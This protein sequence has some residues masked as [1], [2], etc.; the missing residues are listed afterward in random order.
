[1]K[2]KENRKPP[3]KFTG[4]LE[5]CDGL[6]SPTN[7]GIFYYKNGEHH[8]IDAPA[9]V[10]DVGAKIWYKNGNVHN[11]NGP[12]AEWGAGQKQ[13]FLSGTKYSEEQWKI[14]VGKVVKR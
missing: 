14:K 6:G 3:K 4:I 11:E 13:W 7:A 2:L 8:R 9:H 5:M 1:M 10:Y 12:A